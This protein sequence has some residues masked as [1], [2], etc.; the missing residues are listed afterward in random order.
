LEIRPVSGAL[1]GEG[2]SMLLTILIIVAII[3]GIV[4]LVRR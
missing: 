3:C 2:G 1:T 4:F